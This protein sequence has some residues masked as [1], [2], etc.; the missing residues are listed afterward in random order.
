MP[1][2]CSDSGE[3]GLD[4]LASRPHQIIPVVPFRAEAAVASRMQRVPFGPGA[5]AR[6]GALLM[7]AEALEDGVPDGLVEDPKSVFTKV[8]VHVWH[9]EQA[10]AELNRREVGTIYGCV[11][12]SE[13]PPKWPRVVDRDAGGTVVRKRLTDVYGNSRPAQRTVEGR[14]LAVV[15]DRV[16]P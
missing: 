2:G 12:V 15:V 10:Y 13:A 7:A 16:Q 6:T 5:S 14:G 4:M 8:S 9:A 11:V 3:L 1:R